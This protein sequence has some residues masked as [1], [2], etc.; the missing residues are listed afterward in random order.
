MPLLEWKESFRTG[1][2][3][4]DYEHE[5]LIAL[6]NA[7]HARV[8]GGGDAVAVGAFFGDLYAEISSHFALEETVMR[9][10]SYVEYAAHKDDHEQLL[11]AI[12]DIM[13]QYEGGAYAGYGE[14]LGMRLREWFARHF[15]TFDARLHVFLAPP[16]Q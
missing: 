12:R 5:Q 8:E 10:R 1:V 4:L 7:L 9:E 6:I 2:R 16:H 3:E 13:D 15:Q 14:R 11:D